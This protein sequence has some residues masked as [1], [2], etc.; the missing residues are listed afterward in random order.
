MNPMKYWPAL[1][2]ML[3]GACAAETTPSS[4]NP[5]VQEGLQKY[6]AP[7]VCAKR[8]ECGTLASNGY[9]DKQSCIDTIARQAAALLPD[10]S[11]KGKCDATTQQAC[12][13][14]YA[15]AACAADSHFDPRATD[16][17]VPCGFPTGG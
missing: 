6:V 9:A 5:S 13:D 14:K 2:G 11:V 7:A 10:E 4:P 15:T 16:D 3:A 17:C 12:A 8:E 1:F